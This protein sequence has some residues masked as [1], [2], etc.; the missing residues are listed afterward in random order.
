MDQRN[1]GFE[2][3]AI[4]KRIGKVFERR[5]SLSNNQQP[6]SVAVQAM[7]YAGPHARAAVRQLLKVISEC[8]RERTRMNPRG[9]MHDQARWLVHYYECCVFIN[10]LN[11]NGFGSKAG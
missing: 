11:G 3:R 4:A 6:G 10:D 2:H 8:V 7:D 5:L 9:R 1:I